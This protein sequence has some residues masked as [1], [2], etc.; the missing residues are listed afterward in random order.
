MS[1]AIV[2]SVVLERLGVRSWRSQ[3]SHS[4]KVACCGLSNNKGCGMTVYKIFCSE[5]SSLHLVFGVSQ[6]LSCVRITRRLIKRTLIDPIPSFWLSSSMNGLKNSH[7]YQLYRWCWCCCTNDH[8]LRTTK[9]KVLDWQKMKSLKQ[10]ILI[11]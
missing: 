8:N 3:D 7:L 10:L 11:T 9:T 5:E 1:T 4:F 2:G 6:A